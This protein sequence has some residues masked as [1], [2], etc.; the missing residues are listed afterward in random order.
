M[1]ERTLGQ[2]IGDAV[3][4]SIWV[5]T[6]NDAPIGIDDAGLMGDINRALDAEGYTIVACPPGSRVVVSRESKP[7]EVCGGRVAERDGTGY[8]S[9]CG[10]CGGSG[11]VEATTIHGLAE[12]RLGW[13]DEDGAERPLHPFAVE[14]MLYDETLYRMIAL[15][16]ETP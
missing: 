10:A 11:V 15:P 13:I 9:F 1:S 5:F 16:E 6:Q 14:R 2:I 7:C 4:E 12:V 8:V 3:C